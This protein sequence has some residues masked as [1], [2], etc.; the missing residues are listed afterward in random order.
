MRVAKP[1]STSSTS[2][3]Y[4]RALYAKIE[5][6]KKELGLDDATFRDVLEQRYG[7]RSR[8][9]MSDAE[10]VDLV[11]HFKS[12]GFKPKRAKVGRPLAQGAEQRKMR[13]LW[14]TLWNLG[15]IDDASEEALAGFARRVTGG[16]EIGVEALQWL[17]G[18]DAFKVI[19]ALKERATRDGGVSWAPYRRFGQLVG[20]NPRGRVIEAQ[21]RALQRH[22]I[23]I[24]FVDV[25]ALSN[26]EADNII[27]AQG[28]RLRNA[29]SEA[30][31]VR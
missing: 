31:N 20:D 3:T 6:A 8:T 9:G 17:H 30:D 27:A 7:K 1:K 29:M 12:R 15:A 14:L 19:E 24:D 25:H 23:V 10:L 18:D 13:A 26:P 11:E 5:I 21:W 28:A 2:S 4:R 16:K 22:G